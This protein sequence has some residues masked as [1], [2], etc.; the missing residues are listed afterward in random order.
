MN[1]TIP[2]PVRQFIESHHIAFKERPFPKFERPTTVEVV[3]LEDAQGKL[4]VFFPSDCLLDL[5]KVRN[6]LGR[7]MTAMSTDKLRELA[8][9]SGLDTLPALD[10]LLKMDTVIDQRLQEMN[11][12]NL[13][14]GNREYLITLDSTD[15]IKQQENTQVVDVCERIPFNDTD[16]ELSLFDHDREEIYQA[17]TNFTALRIKQR[18]EETLEIPPLPE[19]AQAIIRLRIDPNADINKLAKIVEKDPSLAAQVVSWASSSYYAAPGTVKSVQDAII[20]VLGYDLVMN[21]AL[22]LALGKTLDLPE[23]G[24]EGVTPYWSQSVYTAATIGALLNLIPREFRPGFG[25][26]YLSGLL[27]NFGYLVLAHAFPPHFKQVA[28]Y[29]EANP[30]LANHHV[31]KHLLGITREQIGANLMKSWNMPDEVCIALRYLHEPQYMGPHS[32]YSQLA[33]LALRLLWQNNLVQGPITHIDDSVFQTLHIN[34]D[35]IPEAMTSVIES[36]A[37]LDA[38]AKG[39]LS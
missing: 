2:I 37:E 24:P 21:L 29:I 7:D 28:R 23:D 11:Q 25:L 8:Q 33:Y 32:D 16:Y 13:H 36:K 4:Q 30:H 27:H 22:G 34:P 26:A 31:E 5:E 10:G 19:T 18:L 15:A 9:K 1:T 38:I 20:R 35:D 39:M 17:V 14:S 12:V 6:S 3:V